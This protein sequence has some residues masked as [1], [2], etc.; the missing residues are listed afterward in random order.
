MQAT[1]GGD[2][3]QSAGYGE[4]D[5]ER[6]GQAQLVA[7]CPCAEQE[8]IR[9]VSLNGRR[10]QRT[11]LDLNLVGAEFPGSVQPSQSREDLGIDVRGCVQAMSSDTAADGLTQRVGK[12]EIDERRCIGDD[13]S[14]V[15]WTIRRARRRARPER[16]CG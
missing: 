3:R 9:R 6:V 10:G 1:I 15:V 12:Q 16:G 11:Q 14:H 5:V 13:V 7:S 8:V 2:E 4:F